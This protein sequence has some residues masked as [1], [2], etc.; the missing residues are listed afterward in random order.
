MDKTGV[1]SAAPRYAAALIVA[2]LCTAS[3]ARGRV[4]YEAAPGGRALSFAGNHVAAVNDISATY[5]NP[6]ILAFMPVREFGLSVDGLSQTTATSLYGTTEEESLQRLRFEQAGV[7][8]AAPTSRGG[9]TVGG[10]VCKP[11]IFDDVNVI[12]ASTTR[13]GST[14]RTDRYYKVY[15]QL[16]HWSAG[17]GI[18]P[19]PRLG[20]GMSLGLVGGSEDMRY[21]LY[22]SRNGQVDP[23]G[24]PTD[25]DFEQDIHKNLLGFDIRGGV[26]WEL[27]KVMRLGFTL[28]FPQIVHFEERAEVAFPHLGYADPAI[29]RD[30]GNFRSSYRGAAGG[31][32]YLPFATVTADV[33]FRAPYNLIFIDERIPSSSPAA[34]FRIGAGVAVEAPVVRSLLLRAGYSW[35]EFDTHALLEDV[36]GLE[37]DWSTNGIEASRNYHRLGAGLGYVYENIQLEFGYGVRFWDV[38]T[39]NIMTE[40]HVLHRISL[41]FASGF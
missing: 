3:H 21:D 29:Y 12:D 37:I 1:R 22:K 25:N 26:A 10:L 9:F 35:D 20:L 5:Y 36:K 7:A 14:Y 2:A 27:E 16:T 6:G 40:E 30:G 28:A 24:K 38:T 18:Q 32:W 39:R 41:A 19:A 4:A 23:E 11:L 31:V 8:Y 13:D 33:R 34:H 15:G 17:F